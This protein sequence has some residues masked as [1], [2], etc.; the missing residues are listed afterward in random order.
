MK[1]LTTWV[2]TATLFP[3][4]ALANPTV[5]NLATKWQAILAKHVTVD[6]GVDYVGLAKNRSALDSFINAHKS[7]N[8]KPFTDD[9]K[10]A[11]YIN[12]YNAT[13]IHFLLKHA[14]SEKIAI[15]SKKFLDIEINDISAPG[16]NIWNGDYKVDLGGKKVNLDDIE[17]KLVRG[18]DAGDLQPWTVSKLDPRIHAAVNC[19]AVSCPR[20]RETAYNSKNIDRMLTENIKEFFSSEQQFSKQQDVLKAN[21]IVLWY[22]EDFDSHAQ[23][24]L[25][26]PGAGAYVTEFM[27]SATKDRKWK[28][29]HLKANFNNRSTFSLRLSSAFDFAYDWRPNDKRNMARATN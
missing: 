26:L 29:E 13:M 1:I 10:K 16:G 8:P 5:N 2:L 23:E 3:S 17:H 15:D 4:L 9:E 19:A 21:S 27:T 18:V 14:E 28:V 20:V 24:V 11:L 6:G 25:K 12:L 7:V 22:Y